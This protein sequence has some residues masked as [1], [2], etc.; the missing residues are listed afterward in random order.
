[1]IYLRASFKNFCSTNNDNIKKTV[2]SR[3]ILFFSLSVATVKP[4][5]E[6]GTCLSVPLYDSC[7]QIYS[8]LARLLAMMTGHWWFGF[9]KFFELQQCG[10]TTNILAGFYKH[11]GV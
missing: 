5:F 8:L 7:W 10:G 2:G 6:L 9:K 1:M 4:D 11:K 3:T